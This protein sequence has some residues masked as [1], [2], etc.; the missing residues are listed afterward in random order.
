LQNCAICT[1]KNLWQNT[2]LIVAGR[3]LWVCRNCGHEQYE[4]EPQGLSIPPKILYLDIEYGKMRVWLYDLYGE[5]NKHIRYDM[6]ER[7]KFVTNWAAAWVNPHTY[8]IKGDIISGVATQGEARKAND[9]RILHPLFLL[10]DEADYW[11][12]H[13]SDGFDVKVLKWRFLLHGMGYPSE[14]KK[15]DTFKISGRSRPE[16]RAMDYLLKR[17][18]YTGKKHKLDDDEWRE[19]CEKGTPRLLAKADRYCRQDVRG[20]V[21]LLRTYVRAEEQSGRVVFR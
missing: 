7:A 2:G 9:K 17:L 12:G 13:N 10:M 1:K 11:C 18:G 14:A 3:R 16:S 21:D 8:K 4:E 19:I 6:I 15:V 5:H 20:G